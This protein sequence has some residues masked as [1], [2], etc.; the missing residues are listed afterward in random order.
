[1]IKLIL[2][3]PITLLF[4]TTSPEDTNS[5]R[6]KS[7]AKGMA[8]NWEPGLKL[9]WSDFQSIKKVGKNFSI[10]ASTCG[11]GY[12]GIIQGNEVK[13]NVYV[14]FYCQESWRNPDFGSADVLEHEQLHFDICELYGRKFYKAITELR[15]EDKL[16]EKNILKIYNR[17]VNEY[18][19]FQDE[20][21]DETNHSTIASAQKQWN[22]SIKNEID[23]LDAYANYIEY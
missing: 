23:K 14:R 21:D 3:L 17:L 9:E 11:F 5:D 4:L 12:N 10:A 20:Y 6:C 7:T 16:N 15:K 1:M 22:A 18:D 8:I 2:L 19:E 13:I